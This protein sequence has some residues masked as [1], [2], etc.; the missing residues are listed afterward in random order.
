[1]NLEKSTDNQPNPPPSNAQFD[2]GYSSYPTALPQYTQ[3]SQSLPV[4][5]SQIT[6]NHITYALALFS[7]FTAGL[8]WIIPIVMNYLKRDEARNTWLYSHFDWQI[9]TFWYSIF[10]WVIGVAM[11]VFA[12]GGLF[13]GA[14]FN[15]NHTLGGSFI[16]GAL[17]G[18]MIVVTLLW[19]LYRI[20]RGWIALSNGRAVP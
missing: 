19:H 20:V 10:F 4:T 5:Q 17:G 16:I 1:M 11:V 2:N 7:Y 13:F 12:T 18:L 3:L 14:A 9:K 8:T 15:S 6:Y